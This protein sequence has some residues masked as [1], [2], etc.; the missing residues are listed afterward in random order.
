MEQAAAASRWKGAGVRRV[1][2][3]ADRCRGEQQAGEC[4][5][6]C[7]RWACPCGPVLLCYVQQCW[8]PPTQQR[9]EG[10]CGFVTARLFVLP[11]AC[12]A[13]PRMTRM[14]ASASARCDQRK[15]GPAATDVP[16]AT[17]TRRAQCEA[18]C[19]C[20]TSHTHPQG[21]PFTMQLTPTTTPTKK[22]Q[23][24]LAGT[25]STSPS[26]TCGSGE[27]SA[28][29]SSRWGRHSVIWSGGLTHARP[30]SSAAPPRLAAV[31]PCQPARNERRPHPVAPSLPLP[32]PPLPLAP[33]PPEP[34]TTPPAPP[35]P[36]THFLPP[37]STVARGAPTSPCGVVV[38]CTVYRAGH[39]HH[40]QQRPGRDLHAAGAVHPHLLLLLH[41]LHRLQ[42]G[43]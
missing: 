36:S 35:R 19:S 18:S 32:F 13:A 9:G 1:P 5:D 22:H 6:G 41:Q 14:P 23:P 12:A 40:P 4:M 24:P 10:A 2:C 15:A 16:P 25:W 21:R 26:S 43:A 37:P 7:K 29:P 38:R 3:R 28:A 27:W 20:C 31:L 33:P 11:A 17:S 30:P 39:Q 42:V 34:T 8:P